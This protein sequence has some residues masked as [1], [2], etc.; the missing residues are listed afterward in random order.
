MFVLSRANPASLRRRQVARPFAWLGVIAIVLFV[1]GCVPARHTPSAGPDPAD[2]SVPVPPLRYQSTTGG[3][4]RQ[5]PVEPAPWREQ[6][7]RVAP[8]PKP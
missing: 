8:Q 3:Y 7:D 4:L 5:R 1:S 2:P 6:N